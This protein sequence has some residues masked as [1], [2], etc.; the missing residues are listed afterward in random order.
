ML[1]CTQFKGGLTPRQQLATCCLQK[2]LQATC[3]Q[4]LPWCNAAFTPVCERC[5]LTY[6]HHFDVFLCG[7]ATINFTFSFHAYFDYNHL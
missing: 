1:F 2:M 7:A 3:C 5:V 6:S 4:L